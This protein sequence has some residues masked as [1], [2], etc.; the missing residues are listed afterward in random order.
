MGEM[1]FI[2]QP[3]AER[4]VDMAKYISE[5]KTR[6]MEIAFAEFIN[7]HNNPPMYFTVTPPNPKERR[8]DIHRKPASVSTN[9]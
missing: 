6:E 4:L 8:Y 9:G 7:K 5:F 1:E 3:M 2:P